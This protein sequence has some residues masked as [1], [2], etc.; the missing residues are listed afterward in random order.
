MIL[1]NRLEKIIC[2]LCMVLSITFAGAFLN[3]ISADAYSDDVFL[4][5]GR[6]ETEDIKD[7]F[8]LNYSE[9]VMYPGEKV[10]LNVDSEL[11]DEKTSVSLDEWY[12][13]LSELDSN[14]R[15]G[16]ED[17]S[18]YYYLDLDYYSVDERVSV[19]SDGL[20]NVSADVTEDFIS[21]IMVHIT[22]FSKDMELS[23]YLYC[24][25]CVQLDEITGDEIVATSLSKQLNVSVAYTLGT[26]KWKTLDSKIAS[27]S[28]DG[29][30]TGLSYGIT[31]VQAI[32]SD[33]ETE[34][35]LSKT[36]KVS[37]PKI[38][39]LK[40]AVA[41]GGTYTLPV[42]GIFDESTKTFVSSKKSYA[43]VDEKGNVY[44]LKKTSNAI[45]ITAV[46]DGKTITTKVIVTNPTLKF[47][48]NAPILLVKG[49]SKTIK[50]KGISST[51]SSVSFRSGRTNIAKVSKKGKVKGKKY[52]SCY[53]Y[54]T[55]DYKTFKLNC[56]V[57]KKKAI[58][59]VKRAY[60]AVGC[61]YSQ[62]YR[63]SKG[64]YDCSSLVYRSFKP[65]GCGFGATT[66]W[67]PVA[68]EEYKYLVNAGKSIASK[69]ISYK[70]LRPGDIIFY[71]GWKN[72][73]Y[74]NI[75]HVA[76]FVANNTTIEAKDYDIPI[77]EDTYKKQS[78]VVGIGR[79]F[80]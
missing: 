70:K 64:Q 20:I 27:V 39:V 75:T 80:K 17:I 62:L 78:R 37:D 68:A 60:K 58:K 1:K 10:K 6:D 34:Y 69:K 3:N 44:G 57:G 14:N 53:I 8:S 4:E 5:N 52:G 32:I 51:Y 71:S 36:V 9:L 2:I 55:V 72:G 46:I 19:D 13:L 25:A 45:T 29:I 59:A 61:K 30:V 18:K 63:M 74:L 35:V 42:E 33:G 76:I 67:A 65:Y 15:Q 26:V 48:K 16:A 11:F 23:G 38:N 21:Q 66:N 47:G 49:K 79:V 24:D 22:Y 28:E 56:A 54:V 73:R 41:V 77:G 31:E 43:S 7:Y 40:E 12:A 50:V